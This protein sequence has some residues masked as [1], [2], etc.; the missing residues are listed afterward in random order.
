MNNVLVKKVESPK[1]MSDFISL[2]RTLYKD[3]KQYVDPYSGRPFQ[4][5]AFCFVGIG[6]HHERHSSVR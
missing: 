6:I 1:E 5:T 2:S 3:S 4:L